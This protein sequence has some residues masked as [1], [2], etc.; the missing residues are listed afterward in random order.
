MNTKQ[1]TS[2]LLCGSAIKLLEEKFPGYQEPET[3]GIHYCPYCNTS[4]SLPRVET[5]HLYEQI[6]QKGDK[7]PGYDRY[8]RYMRVVKNQTYPLQYLSESEEAYWGIRNALSQIAIPK[9]NLKIIEVGCGLGYLTYA[10]R[11]EGYNATG[12]D[13]SQNAIDDAVKNFG[14]HYICADVTEYAVQHKAS[15]DV[16]ILSEVIEHIDAPV[17]FLKSLADLL[18]ANVGQILL[19]TPNKT[20]FP[21]NIVWNTDLPPI[22]LWWFSENSMHYIASKINADVLFV[23]FTDYYKKRQVYYDTKHQKSIREIN[24]VFNINGEIINNAKKKKLY[25]KL[26]SIIAKIPW[27]KYLYNRIY[28]KAS[29]KRCRTLVTVFKIKSTH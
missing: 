12:L 20:V 2:C 6:Y 23:D 13:I 15:Y 25:N 28:L 3:F 22:H 19:S 10:L 1:P 5:S 14:K 16:V 29:G 9:E 27:A 21:A 7:V 8:W 24:H 18:T 17:D 11:Q 4:F 26:R